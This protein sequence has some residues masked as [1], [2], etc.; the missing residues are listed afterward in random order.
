[1]SDKTKE[2]IANMIRNL[3]NENEE[4]AAKDFSEVTTIKSVEILGTGVLPEPQQPEPTPEPA[5]E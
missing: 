1:M 3:A 5:A 2:C 4:A